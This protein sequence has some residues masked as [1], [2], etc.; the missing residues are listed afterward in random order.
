MGA[1]NSSFIGHVSGGSGP[2]IS[3]SEQERLDRDPF[4]IVISKWPAQEQE[5]NADEARATYKRLLDSEDVKKTRVKLAEVRAKLASAESQ[6][7]ASEF[8]TRVVRKRRLLL[9]ER[10]R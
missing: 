1:N 10:D 3:R 8:N 6:L 7:A 2:A 5:R 9:Q 4:L